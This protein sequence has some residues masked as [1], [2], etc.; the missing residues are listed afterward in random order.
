MRQLD[1][2]L[3]SEVGGG[4]NLISPELAVVG[5]MTKWITKALKP[6]NSNLY[7]ML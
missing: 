3:S 1:S 2:M 5:L 6:S 7:L 4:L